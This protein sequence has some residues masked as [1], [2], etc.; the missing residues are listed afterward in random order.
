M[1]YVDTSIFVALC[2]KEQK[3]DDVAKWYTNSQ[4]KMI[5]STWAFT[6]FSS[7]LSLK[8]RT[9]QITEKQS[10]EA[11]KKF[12][13]LCQNDIELLPIESKAYYSAGILVVDS[14]S[15]LRAGDALH[16]AAA[17]QS[18][19]KF[20]ATLDKVLAKNA[21]NLKIQTVLI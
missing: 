13:S 11:W 6:E 8:V 4:A 10:R 7:A 9:S 14:K 20:L 5:S 1:I 19:S 17:K 15:N 3:S 16:L 2:T 21:G 12:D 18:K